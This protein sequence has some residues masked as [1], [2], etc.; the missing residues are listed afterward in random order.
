MVSDLYFAVEEG[1]DIQGCDNEVEA[2]KIITQ[3]KYADFSH[4]DTDVF[5]FEF[6]YLRF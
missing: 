3:R 4:S 6:I 5:D 2:D 1:Q